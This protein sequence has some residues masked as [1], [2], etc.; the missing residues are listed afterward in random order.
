MCL[1]RYLIKNMANLNK[2]YFKQ[3]CGTLYTP[4]ETSKGKLPLIYLVIFCTRRL[5]FALTIAFLIEYPMLQ[6][7]LTALI[8]HFVLIWHVMVWPMESKRHNILYLINEY[9]YMGCCFFTLAFSEYNPDPET[10]LKCG[11]IYLLFIALIV[12]ANFVV[13]IIDMVLGIMDYC[14]QRKLHQ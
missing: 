9:L 14:H 7:C 11:W 12:I 10:R 13:M 2:L 5:L 8:S 6:I 3:S 1:T 4:C